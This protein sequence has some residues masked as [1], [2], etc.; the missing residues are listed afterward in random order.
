MRTCMAV[1]LLGFMLAPTPARADEE[2]PAETVRKGLDKEITLDFVGQSLDEAVQHLREKTKLNFVVEN[3]P[4]NP[5]FNG[6]GLA[7]VNVNQPMATL[8]ITKGKVRQAVQRMLQPFSLTYVVV[9]DT[10]VI[11]TEEMG[12]QRQMKQ[13]VQLDVDKT[14]LNAALKKLGKAYAINLVID[15]KVSKEAE[16]PVSLQLD[17][18]ALDNAVRL[19]AEVGGLKAVRLGN[20]LFVTDEAKATKI[21]K[22]E[23]SNSQPVSPY[24][25]SPYGGIGFG[26]IGVAPAPALPPLPAKAAPAKVVPPDPNNPASAPAKNPPP[27]PAP[28]AVNRPSGVDPNVP[29]PIAPPKKAVPDPSR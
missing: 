27:R 3:N 9:G 8:K 17:D 13:R 22:E 19:L 14:P 7:N 12:V 24:A 28:P 18:A 1:L 23:K 2:S 25:T 4:L 26:G 5:F 15:P 21:R 11:T 6:L 20:V 16:K 10:V 29:P